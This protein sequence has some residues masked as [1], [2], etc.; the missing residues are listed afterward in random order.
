MLNNLN[1]N[2]KQRNQFL[3][4]AAEGRNEIPADIAELITEH[5]LELDKIR[6][7]LKELLKTNG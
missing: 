7:S 4:L 5:P 3:D 6:S 2:E 1:V